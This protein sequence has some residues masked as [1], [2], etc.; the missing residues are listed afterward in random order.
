MRALAFADISLG[1]YSV[2]VIEALVSK[3]CQPIFTVY[4]ITKTTGELIL[5]LAHLTSLSSAC[6]QEVDVLRV[7]S[8]L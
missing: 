7:V 3:I 1:N 8:V 6:F 4:T 5:Y 2:S